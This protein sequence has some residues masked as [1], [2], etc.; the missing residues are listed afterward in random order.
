LCAFVSLVVEKFLLPP[1]SVHK[2]F[3]AILEM[4]NIEVYKQSNGFAT[5]LKVRKDLGLMDRGDCV[6]GLN[7]HYD[8]VLNQQVH[9]IAQIELD[10]RYTTG[11]PT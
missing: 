8:Q 4:N 3:E 9:A 5:E 1:R 2:A 10:P 6:N 7:L 11:N